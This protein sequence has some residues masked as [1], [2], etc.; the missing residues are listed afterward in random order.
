MLKRKSAL[1]KKWSPLPQKE[2]TE[3][4]S[5]YVVS[6][7][8]L[9]YHAKYKRWPKEMQIGGVSIKTQKDGSGLLS[10]RLR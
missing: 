1:S 9:S 6:G 5:E 8:V 2:F 7:L 10:A 4:L 3:W